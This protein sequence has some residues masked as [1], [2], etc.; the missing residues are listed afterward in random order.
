[1]K[2]KPV[3]VLLTILFVLSATC[4]VLGLLTHNKNSNK[5][6][7]PVVVKKE[8]TFEYYLEEEKVDTMPVNDEEN[9]YE[10]N[11]FLCDNNMSIDFNSEEWTYTVINETD[12]VCRLYFLRSQY[13]VTLTATNGL[14]DSVEASSTF[15]VDRQTD[16][17]FI[18]VPNEGYE[19]KTASCSNDKEALFDISTNTLTINSITEDVACKVDFEKRNLRVDVT[20][21]NGTGTTTEYKDYGEE[22]SFVVKPNEGYE[23]A[24]IECTNE[25]KFTYEDNQLSIQ[26]LTDNT[27][28]TVTFSKTPAVTYNL[29]INEISEQVT[30]I[31]G[32]MQQ[33][34][35]Q[36]KDG[37]FSIR[38]EDG[39]E[40]KLDCNGVKPSDVQIGDDGIITYTFLGVNNNIT[41]KITTTPIETPTDEDGN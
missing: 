6:S 23:K 27:Q 13:N 30:I 19:Y 35:V 11:R 5:P 10:F 12:G 37:K 14:I 31:A 24:K 38:V 20:V 18:V 1:M 8:V 41:C 3:I 2:N 29:I 39:Y 36:G 15:S 21:K 34:I 25:Q 9:H 4:S 32:N 26:K 17:Q 16:G 40:P 28:C 33:T 22:I 7:D